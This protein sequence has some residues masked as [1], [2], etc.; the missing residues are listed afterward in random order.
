MPSTS[1]RRRSTAPARSWPGWPSIRRTAACRWP[2]S[3]ARPSGGL[4]R[5]CARTGATTPRPR[6]PRTRAARPGQLLAHRDGA[7][8]VATGGG[9]AVW[10][11]HAKA[12][13]ADGGRGLKLPAVQAVPA[14]LDGLRESILHAD[15][16][17][18]HGRTPQGN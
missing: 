7:V 15:P 1:S 9:G 4:P 13:L 17:L 18:H 10:I 3:V 12:K 5:A 14:Q 16:P 8:L 11:G 6:A 2:T